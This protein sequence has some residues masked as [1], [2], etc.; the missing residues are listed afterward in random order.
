MRHPR[1]RRSGFVGVD[2]PRPLPGL[3]PSFSIVNCILSC[4][5]S[6]DLVLHSF[7]LPLQQPF[8]V[9][10]PPLQPV[11][12]PSQGPFKACIIVST[13]TA[14][15]PFTP[16]FGSPIISIH[17]RCTPFVRSPIKGSKPVSGFRL[18]G[19]GTASFP[20]S[21]V[22]RKLEQPWRC[23]L[24]SLWL[25]HLSPHSS[26]CPTP[27]VFLDASMVCSV[28]FSKL[29]FCRGSAPGLDSFLVVFVCLFFL[30]FWSSVS[31]QRETHQVL[32]PRGLLA[33]RGY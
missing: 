26:S 16:F 24:F 4:S 27:A 13:L 7:V 1:R 21:C 8:A 32:F 22:A 19:C 15:L 33:G 2:R 20:G 28:S 9:R 6:Y 17:S 12:F 5:Y 29:L 14:S 18:S 25:L 23:S 11:P 10:V 30:L 31:F 3:V